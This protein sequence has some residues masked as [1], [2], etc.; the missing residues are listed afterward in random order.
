[1]AMR[2]AAAQ[3]SGLI[4]TTRGSLESNSGIHFRC[5]DFNKAGTMHSQALWSH[6][7]NGTTERCVVF[8]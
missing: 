4:L 7:P 8:P 3:T 5:V 1:M 2:V 6:A